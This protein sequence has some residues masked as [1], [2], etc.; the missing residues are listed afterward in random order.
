[1]STSSCP[2]PLIE[3][4]FDMWAQVFQFLSVLDLLRMVRRVKCMKLHLSTL[5]SFSATKWGCTDWICPHRQYCTATSSF[6]VHIVLATSETKRHVLLHSSGWSTGHGQ[7]I[8]AFLEPT[9]NEYEHKR[10]RIRRG[11]SCPDVLF[12]WIDGITN[13]PILNNRYDT[14]WRSEYVTRCF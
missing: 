11:V 13:T 14:V 5:G 1:M 4:P 6:Y 7:T 3:L 8:Q 10:V 12:V 9:Y 2:S